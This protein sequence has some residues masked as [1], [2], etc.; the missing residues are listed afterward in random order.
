M[1]P[2]LLCL[3]GWGGDTSS[4]NELRDA[5]KDVDIKILAPDLPGFGA[6]PEPPTAWT[7]DDYVEW[8]LQYLRKEVPDFQTQKLFLIG[9]S[10][11]GRIA[12]KMAARGT[13]PIEHLYLCAAAGI[14]HPRHIKR[15]IGLTMAKAGKFFLS[16]PGLRVLEPLGKK[17]LYKLVRVHDYEKAS[18]VMRQTLINVTRE[19]L[20]SLLPSIHVPTDIFWGIDDG[21][22]PV[23]D[24]KLMHEKIPGSKLHL[25]PGIRHRVHRD[26]AA[27]IAAVIRANQV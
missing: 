20:R 12:I 14:H 8:V 26:R 22:T 11:G 15:V 3:H 13:P 10:H 27:D 17:L 23:S 4:W 16:V 24:G 25:F 18:P 1:T 9:H 19:D 5:L 2:L 21:M 6:Q 7:T